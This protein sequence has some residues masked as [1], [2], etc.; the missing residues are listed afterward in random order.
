MSLFTNSCFKHINN[1]IDPQ[2]SNFHN[3]IGLM[4]LVYDRTTFQ[5]K[6]LK[7]WK[8]WMIC[9]TECLI[10]SLLN[11]PKCLKLSKSNKFYTD[12]G[13]D[14]NIIP[15]SPITLLPTFSQQTAPYFSSHLNRYAVYLNSSIVHICQLWFL[16]NIIWYWACCNR[17]YQHQIW[18]FTCH[19]QVSRAGISNYIPH[20]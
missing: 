6:I 7:S 16:L 1:I 10:L 2:F 19:K 11:W 5:N 8:C 4:D 14:K 13:N 3:K 12:I 20:L 9:I 17:T 18:E 15:L